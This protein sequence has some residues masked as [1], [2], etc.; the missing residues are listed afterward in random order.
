MRDALRPEKESDVNPFPVAFHR[1]NHRRGIPC[2]QGLT[3]LWS[4]N[5]VRNKST[6]GAASVTLTRLDALDSFHDRGPNLVQ[7][8]AST[9]WA[10]YTGECLETLLRYLSMTKVTDVRH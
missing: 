7:D 1:I 8:S 6:T 9:V 4:Q 10:L 3:S 5:V 2:V